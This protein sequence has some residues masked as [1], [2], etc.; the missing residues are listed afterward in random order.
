MNDRLEAEG[1]LL[2]FELAGHDCAVRLNRLQEIV[3]MARLS[4]PPGL[5]S[6]MEGFLNL[7][8]TAVGVLRLDRL[9]D[10]GECAPDLYSTL[11]IVNTNGC[12]IAW[13]VD[14]VS[15]IV[16]D[17]PEDRSPVAAELS[18]NGCAEVEVTVNGRTIHLLSPERILLKQERR[19]VE[20]FQALEQQRLRNLTAA[21]T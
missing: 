12:P 6:I 7:G 10:L 18:F 3:P 16:A 1:S 15:E 8:G 9:L 19:T 21:T 5:P 20:D 13:L 2:V 17:S 4:H 11:L 14:S